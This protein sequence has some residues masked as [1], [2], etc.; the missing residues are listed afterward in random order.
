MNAF[1]GILKS[2]IP[3]ALGVTVGMIAYEQIKKAT[4]KTI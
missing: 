4:T 3:V 1:V 2:M